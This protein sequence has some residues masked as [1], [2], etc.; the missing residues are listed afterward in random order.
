VRLASD[1]GGRSKTVSDWQVPCGLGVVGGASRR[2]RSFHNR[3]WFSGPLQAGYQKEH[4]ETPRP[5]GA[6]QKN[7][8]CDQEGC[9][10]A[11]DLVGAQGTDIRNRQTLHSEV[12]ALRI[13]AARE[14]LP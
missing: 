12:I 10:S 3:G 8:P 2:R 4:G 11:P 9:P 1:L 14:S 7:S 6:R 13:Q 5:R